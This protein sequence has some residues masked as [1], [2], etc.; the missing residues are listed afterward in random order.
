[1]VSYVSRAVLAACALSLSGCFVAEND[2]IDPIIPDAT[3]AYPLKAGAA[4]ECEER[5]DDTV[6]KRV[7]ISR[8]SGGGYELRTWDPQA[9]PGD[10]P[11]RESY[12]LRALKGK[13]I[14]ANAYLVQSVQSL[15]DDHV[16]GL[17]IRRP[18]G[19][20]VKVSPQCDNLRPA[21][22]VAFINDGWI[23]TDNDQLSSMKCAIRREGLTDER[24]YQILDAVKKPSYPTL[25]YDGQ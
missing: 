24:I 17:M 16:L 21:A 22:F 12:R 15:S 20:W 13:G 6:C 23:L 25:I 14:P 18:D 5:E 8:L 2:D 4:K 10:E 1:M 9:N 7:E 3:L 19:G 11:T